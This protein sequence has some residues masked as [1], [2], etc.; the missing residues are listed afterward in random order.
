V[1]CIDGVESMG[2]HPITVF[3]EDTWKGG[4]KQVET[5]FFGG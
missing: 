5:P 4:K 2:W 3:V 1:L